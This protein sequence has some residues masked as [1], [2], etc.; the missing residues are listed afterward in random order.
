MVSYISDPKTGLAPVASESAIILDNLIIRDFTGKTGDVSNGCKNEKDRTNYCRMKFTSDFTV[1][2]ER[3]SEFSDRSLLK[4]KVND[5]TTNCTSRCG[6]RVHTMSVGEKKTV[7]ISRYVWNLLGLSVVKVE[8]SIYGLRL[9][10]K[11]WVI[12]RPFNT[13]WKCQMMLRHTSKRVG[14]PSN[15]YIIYGQSR[16]MLRSSTIYYNTHWRT[17][18]QILIVTDSNHMAYLLP[19]ARQQ[20][21]VTGRRKCSLV[22]RWKNLHCSMAMKAIHKCKLAFIQ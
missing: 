2:I 18:V 16:M 12:N 7:D 3:C 1:R 21:W 20:V 15:R 13:S 8:W 6:S 11:D 4:V 10:I 19:N 17:G 14:V 9:F 22:A 5:V